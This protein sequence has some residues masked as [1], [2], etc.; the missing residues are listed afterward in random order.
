MARALTAFV[1]L[2][3]LLAGAQACSSAMD[4]IKQAEGYRSCEYMDTT[5]H[6]TICY[7]FNLDAWGASSKVAAVGGDFQKVYNGGCLSQSQCDSLLAGAVSSAASAARGIFGSQC[8]CIE[9]VLTD[10]TYNLGSAGISSF[11]TFI[12]LIK[13]GKW[14]AAASDA[15]G[16]LWCSQVGSRCSRDASIIAGG[17]SGVEAEEHFGDS[18]DD[19]WPPEEDAAAP[20][21]DDLVAPVVSLDFDRES[22]KCI[23]EAKKLCGHC[24]FNKGCWES[25]AQEHE[26]ALKAAGCTTAG[27]PAEIAE[28]DE[29][30]EPAS[31]VKEAKK[32]CGHCGL[33][34]GCWESC[35]SAHESQLKAA[36]CKTVS[37]EAPDSVPGYITVP[38]HI[39]DSTPTHVVDAEEEAA[40]AELFAELGLGGEPASCVKEAK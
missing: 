8:S 4:L 7:G 3:A 20:G 27:E 1:A 25:C 14:S 6:R 2:A 35:A 38:T 18:H 32:L 23:A 33:D 30:G 5:G 22:A 34:K 17:C 12:S 24:G 37:A 13:Q 15:R 19:L 11:T 40:T 31:C 28:I 16:T 21:E 39:V 26:S 36:G 9:A 10:M 29:G